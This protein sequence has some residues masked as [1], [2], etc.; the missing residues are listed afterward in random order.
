MQLQIHGPNL[1]QFWRPTTLEWKIVNIL[2][3]KVNCQKPSLWTMNWVK[4]PCASW[5]KK[6]RTLLHQS[7]QCKS[8]KI[9]KKRTSILKSF[10]RQQIR[11]KPTTCNYIWHTFNHSAID[12][13]LIWKGK[14][15]NST[16]KIT[17]KETKTKKEY[18][19]EETN[20]AILPWILR[21]AS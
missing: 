20:F 16:S 13:R 1:I 19:R 12:T 7:C 8:L 10:N 4:A 6:S 21:G 14:S 15:S 18:H 5:C 3:N 2:N 17:Q 11:I 9:G